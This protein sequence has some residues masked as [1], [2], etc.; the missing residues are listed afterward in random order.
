MACFP[1]EKIQALIAVRC[2]V[3]AKALSSVLSESV[4]LVTDFPLL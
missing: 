1:M 3:L 2:G 4:G